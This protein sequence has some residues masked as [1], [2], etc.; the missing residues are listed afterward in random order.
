MGGS[1]NNSMVQSDG[2]LLHLYA[3]DHSEEAFTELVE[4]HINIVHAAALRQLGGDGSLAEEVTQRVFSELAGKAILLTGRTS[5][6]GWLYGSTRF[7]ALAARRAEMRRRK[8]EQEAYMMEQ[9]NHSS[10]GSDQD[11][12][13]LSAVLDE[14]MHELGKEDREA[15][16]LRYFKGCSLKEVGDCFGVSDNAARMRVDR[17]LDKLRLLLAKRGVLSTTAVLAVLFT[18]FAAPAAPRALAGRIAKTALTGSIATG[19]IAGFWVMRTGTKILLGLA[20]AIILVVFV[21][22]TSSW[23]EKSSLSLPGP[24]PI[25]PAAQKVP[26]ASPANDETNAGTNVPATPPAAASPTL[27]LKLIDSR[28][29]KPVTGVKVDCFLRPFNPA[30]AHF[31]LTVDKMGTVEVPDR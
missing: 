1:Y 27:A 19:T 23:R 14:T 5:I 17:A 24:K 30:S 9:T 28:S 6:V 7:C 31:V 8:R 13:Q 29:G 21:P 11:W 26:V 25:A 20:A 4:R 2:E 12:T 15:V 22:L 18:S 10:P 3:N 16:L